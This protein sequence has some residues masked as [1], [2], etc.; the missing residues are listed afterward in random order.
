[1]ET[2]NE[3]RMEM[4]DM[5]NNVNDLMNMYSQMQSNPTQFLS[6][7]FSIPKDMNNPNDII[8]HLLNSGQVSQGQVNNLMQLR[9]NPMI[10]KIFGKR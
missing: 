1:M 3:I 8:Q 10:Q 7:R 4:L 9:N 2:A 6:Q 5:M